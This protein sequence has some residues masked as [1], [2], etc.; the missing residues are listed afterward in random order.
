MYKNRNMLNRERTLRCPACHSFIDHVPNTRGLGLRPEDILLPQ[1]GDVTECDKCRTMLEYGGNPGCLT[2]S[3]ARRQ[4]IDAF[5]RLSRESGRKPKLSKL[6]EYVMKYRQMPGADPEVQGRATV[7][8]IRKPRLSFCRSDRRN[9]EL[10]CPPR[11][12]PK[13]DTI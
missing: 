5:H 7:C 9:R 1:P 4:R 13:Q 2:L 11:T 6:V 12:L 10:I 3:F 8:Q